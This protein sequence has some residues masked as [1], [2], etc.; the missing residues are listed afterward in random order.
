MPPFLVK[1]AFFATFAKT[2]EKPPKTT[3]IISIDNQ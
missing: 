2:T 3:K 1:G